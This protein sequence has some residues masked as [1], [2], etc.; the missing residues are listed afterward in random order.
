M[1]E[2]DERRITLI[3]YDKQSAERN[4]DFSD[5]S[6]NRIVFID[7]LGLLRSTIASPLVRCDS[8]VE[9]VVLDRCCSEAE[10]LSLLAELPHAFAGDILLIRG[11][12][13]GF[14]SATARGGDRVLYAL[15]PE[16]IE[17]YLETVR[18]VQASEAMKR[19]VLKFR[20]R[21]AG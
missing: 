2:R 17:F 13:T 16:D 19:H 3:T 15:S 10:Y 7:S 21:I 9:R 4:W 1:M 11:D 14:L 6:S 5:Q 12:S 8:D 18:L 20:P